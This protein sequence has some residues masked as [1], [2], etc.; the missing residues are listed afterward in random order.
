VDPQPNGAPAVQIEIRSAG[1]ADRDLVSGLLDAGWGST[2]IAIHDE[3]IDASA[4]AALLA[5]RP[6]ADVSGLLT[7]RPAT[8]PGRPADNAWEIV[9]LNTLVRGV[10]V[11]TRL[12]DSLEESA[13]KVGVRWLWGMTTN[14]NLD[15]L[16]LYQ[17]R[18]FRIVAV[19]PDA[20]D[21]AR[22][23]KPSIPAVGE[24]GI[25]IRDELRLAKDLSP[26]TP[27]PHGAAAASHSR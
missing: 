15:A 10:G 11:A 2:L 17:R 18:G 25:P 23:L 4:L 9:T 8:L 13:R 7:W 3:M 1:P 6:G 24:Y 26:A 27:A 22:S 14:D 5:Q 21:R 12:I 16:R 19:E 20:V